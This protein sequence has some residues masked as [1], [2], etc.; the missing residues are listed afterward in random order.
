MHLN[1]I[2]EFVVLLGELDH[3]RPQVVFLFDELSILLDKM[4]F[5]RFE[6]IY[7]ALEIFNGPA[8]L[9]FL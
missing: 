3:F 5:L 6:S 9:Y 4:L 8:V 7:G 1:V 2:V